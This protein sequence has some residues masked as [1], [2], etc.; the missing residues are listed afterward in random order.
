M[1]PFGV[2]AGTNWAVAKSAAVKARM[3]TLLESARRIREGD[4]ETGKR[5]LDTPSVEPYLSA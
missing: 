4:A 5:R 3:R 2:P 1:P